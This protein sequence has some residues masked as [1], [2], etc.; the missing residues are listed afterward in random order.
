M[1]RRYLSATALFLLFPC[2]VFA[3]SCPDNYPGGIAPTTSSRNIVEL[4]APSGAFSTLYNTAWRLPL[5]S[6]EHLTASHLRAHYK[7]HVERVNSFRPDDRLDH[8]QR[9]ELADYKRSGFDRGHMAPDAD[10][11]SADSEYDTFVLSNMI[12]Q[13]P[14]NNRGLHAHIEAAVRHAAMKNGEL[15]VFTGP[16]FLNSNV[17]RI[18]NRIPVPDHL[19]KLVY[20]PKTNRAAAYLEENSNDEGQSYKTVSE[21][22]L[23]RMTGI[24]FLPN[25]NP[26]PLDLP[27]PKNR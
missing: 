18:H 5:V 12:P 2:T 4:C 7:R 13:E 17:S 1:I 11:W 24:V 10:S 3:S 9:A 22:E 19:Y 6:V 14:V 15:F 25:S 27:K 20:D 8:A 23:A 26:E 21:Q 16:L